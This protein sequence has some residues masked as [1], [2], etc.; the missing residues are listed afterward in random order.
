MI[1]RLKNGSS[2]QLFLIP[3]SYTW[4]GNLH[5]ESP[6][7]QSEMCW[8]I[9][10]WSLVLSPFVSPI[11]VPLPK[12]NK[13]IL[14]YNEYLEEEPMYIPRKFWNG[15]IYTINNQEKNIYNKLALEKLKTEME[16]LTNRREHF[17]NSID[18]IDKEIKQFLDNKSI[19]KILRTEVLS[20]W[21]KEC[22]KDINRLQDI[23]KKKIEGTKTTFEKDQAFIQRKSNSNVT[24]KSNEEN[25]VTNT[26][27]ETVITPMRKEQIHLIQG[28]RILT[29]TI[30]IGLEIEATVT[31]Q[32][33]GVTNI[34]HHAKDNT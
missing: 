24:N 28:D 11:Y 18:T 19:P 12:C 20:E 23:W 5:V 33:T 10:N 26:Q 6:V 17:R 3:Q 34:I 1:F 13:Q 9:P 4:R 27:K 30:N 15:K 8:F 32:K 21:E 14:Q 16:I 2:R 29:T 7:L 25:N 22:Q 31:I